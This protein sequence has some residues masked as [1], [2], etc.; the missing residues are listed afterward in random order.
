MGQTRHLDI[1][2]GM[3]ISKNYKLGPPVQSVDELVVLA[4][5]SK[6]VFNR[7]SGLYIPATRVIKYWKNLYRLY[8]HV[9]RKGFYTLTRIDE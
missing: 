6:A 2:E 3:Q 7:H 4:G 8:Y 1:K 5:K 9:H